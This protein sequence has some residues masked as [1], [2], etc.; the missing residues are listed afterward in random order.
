MKEAPEQLAER[1]GLLEVGCVAGAR[2]HRHLGVL[3]DAAGHPLGDEDGLGVEA[4]DDGQD[5]HPQLPEAVP[6]RVLLAGP[7]QA[8]GRR[9]PGRAVG[10]PG[11]EIRLGGDEPGEDLLGEPAV[12]EGARAEPLDVGGQLLVAV[13]AGGA[14]ALVGEARRGSDQHEGLHQRRPVDGEPQGEAS[15]HRVAD[16]DASASGGAHCGRGLGE[17]ELHPFRGTVSGEVHAHDLEAA[18]QQLGRLVPR[19]RGLGEAVDEDDALGP[20]RFGRAVT[21][22]IDTP[23]EHVGMMT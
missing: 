21:R 12:E 22:A 17:A 4:A 16:V 14:V 20:S 3:P 18:C 10:T 19:R 8:Q 6:Q 15:T 7:E 1:L 23:G 11:G 13:A 5:G 2:H 9:Q